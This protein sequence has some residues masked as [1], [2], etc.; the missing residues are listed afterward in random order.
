MKFA[1]VK[2]AAQARYQRRLKEDP[3]RWAERLEIARFNYERRVRAT[4]REVDRRRRRTHTEPRTSKAA[5]LPA[6][7]FREWF[8]DWQARHPGEALRRLAL[9]SGVP[10]RSLWRVLFEEQENI[11]VAIVDEVLT[12]AGEQWLLNEMYPLDEEQ[13]AA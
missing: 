3:A 7:P 6:G 9:S 11:S 5:T 12:A 8:A 10:E 13:L 4:G 2:K 1:A